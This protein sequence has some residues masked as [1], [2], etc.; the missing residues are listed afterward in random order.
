MRSIVSKILIQINAKIGG[1]PWT[2]TNLPLMNVP[3]MIVAI[4]LYS[5]TGRN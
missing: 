3:A 1:I 2:V 5:N 4:D